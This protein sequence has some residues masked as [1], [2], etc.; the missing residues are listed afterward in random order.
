MHNILKSKLFQV[1][2]LTGLIAAV[3]FIY[4]EKAPYAESDEMASNGSHDS[5]HIVCLDVERIFQEAKVFTDIQAQMEKRASALQSET[6][7]KQ[8]KMQEKHKELE[9][10]KNALSQQAYEDSMN[11]LKEEFEDAN[12]ETYKMRLVLDRAYKKSLKDLDAKFSEILEDYAKSKGYDYILNKSQVV[13]N[14]EN[15]DITA[16]VKEIFDSELPSYTIK[17]ESV[18]DIEG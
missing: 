11:K 1:L 4:N 5:L 18:E 14:P 9:A 8:E 13:Y 2:V 16:E 7:E 6:A 10:K 15:V 12:R 17:F 3:F